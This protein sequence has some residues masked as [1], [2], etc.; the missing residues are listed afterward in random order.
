MYL[1]QPSDSWLCP[2]TIGYG[3]GLLLALTPLPRQPLAHLNLSS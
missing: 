3:R 2:I 1:V